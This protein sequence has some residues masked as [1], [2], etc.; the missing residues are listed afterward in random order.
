MAVKMKVYQVS[1]FDGEELRAVVFE[2]LEKAHAKFVDWLHELEG[3]Y[4]YKRGYEDLA[5]EVLERW[6]GEP[7]FIM[8]KGSADPFVAACHCQLVLG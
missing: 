5:E 2:D 8:G 6:K 1:Y 4:G 3:E 7:L